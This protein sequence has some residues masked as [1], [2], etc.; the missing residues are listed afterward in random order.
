MKKILITVVAGLCFQL[1]IA[2]VKEGKVI[3]ERKTNMHKR[4]PPENANM[5][6]MIP[7]FSTS[8]QQLVFSGDES[9]FSSLPDEEDIRDQAGQDGGTRMNIRMGGGNNETYKNYATEK[10]IELRELG[11]KK[12]IIVDTLKKIAWKLLEDT[13]TIKGY[14]CKK[15]TAKNKQGDNIVAWYTE[16]IATPS[17]PEQFG[18]LPGLILT[19]DIGDSFIVFSAVDIKASGDKQIVKIPSGAKKITRQEFQK[20]MDEAFG[21]SNGNGGP[22]IRI[23]TRDGGGQRN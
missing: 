23:I 8:K 17:G 16:D 6:A 18:G 19:M 11:P 2:Q 13:S 5:K 7:E 4:L 20:M 9:I 22:Q 10:I 14:H 3:Y 1:V 21:P 12:Y 15:A